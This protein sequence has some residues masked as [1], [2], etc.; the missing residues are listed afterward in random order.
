MKL[1]PAQFGALHTLREFGPK[2]GALVYGPAAMSGERKAKLECRVMNVATMTALEDRSLI[3]VVR[4]GPLR[5][6][7]ATGRKGHPRIPVKIEITDAGRAAL[8]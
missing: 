3:R 5:P 8:E 2:H 4:G 1:T 7:D 6:V